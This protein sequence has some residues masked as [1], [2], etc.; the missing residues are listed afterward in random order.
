MPDLTQAY[1]PTLQNHRLPDLD[2]EGSF[3]YPNYLGYSILNIP[4]SL[5]R[6]MGIP[7]FGTGPLQIRELDELAQRARR[8]IF[9]LMDALGLQLFQE[10]LKKE[11]LAV[12]HDLLKGGL[13]APLTSITPST[14]SA[15]LTS[16]WTGRSPAEHGII[17]Y[18]LW[19]KE[20]GIVT[21]MI[22]H[23]PIAY[24]NDTGSLAKAGFQ[25]ETYLPFTNLGTHLGAHGVKPYAFQ[26]TSIV[27]SGLSQMLYKD[28]ETRSFNTSTDLWL[29]LRDLINGRPAERQ[30]IWVYW[31]EVDHYSHLYGP[32]DERPAAEFAT[33]SQTFE[34]LLLNQLR[35]DTRKD[36][37]LI[38]TADHGQITTPHNPHY[39]LRNHPE[40]VKRL[41]I[42]PTGENRFQYL[43]VRPGQVESVQEYYQR[44]WPGQFTFLDPSQAVREGLFGPGK[45]HAQIEDRLGDTLV[46]ARENAYLWW[47]SKDNPM[48]GRHGGLSPEEMLV[49]FLMAR[50]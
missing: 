1:L 21:N 11:P 30:L 5:C 43:F 4:S 34:K 48:L 8:I 49:P 25:P 23:A 7:S 39:E 2:L 44:S 46:L 47:A 20:Y 29:N 37:L 50:L 28:V 9:I 36:T 12:W 33:F 17:G 41:H 13:L 27:R 16:L 19:L 24:R 3:I 35:A 14:T 31:G 40:L 32:E 42:L 38:L 18:E 26:H 6:W 15:A 45:P 22:L 10:L